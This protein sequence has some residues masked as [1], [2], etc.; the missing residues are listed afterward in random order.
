MIHK[1]VQKIVFAEM[2]RR[3]RRFQSEFAKGWA[4]FKPASKE[5]LAWL[6]YRASQDDWRLA[7]EQ[8]IGPFRDPYNDRWFLM[9]K[10]KWFGVYLHHFQRS[11]DDRALHDH[12]WAFNI[13]WLLDGDYEEITFWRGV[14]P[15]VM[16]TSN[17]YAWRRGDLRGTSTNQVPSMGHPKKRKEGAL[18]FRW[19][20]SPHRVLL[21]DR[22][23]RGSYRRKISGGK[24]AVWTIFI[25][26]PKVREWGF[27]CGSFWRHWKDFTSSDGMRGRGCDGDPADD[28]HTRRA[29]R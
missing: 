16:P 14:V 18:I 4:P 9:P 13:S 20:A 10:N 27:Y 11:D 7:P 6:Q 28:K 8:R 15:Y 24:R 2:E 26:G 1:L 23:M 3:H 17:R 12:P 21:Y 25:V 22:F 29:P 5:E 19:G